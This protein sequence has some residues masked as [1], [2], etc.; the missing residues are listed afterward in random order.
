[1]R[2][3]ISLPDVDKIVGQFI[4]QL[5]VDQEHVDITV[6]DNPGFWLEK[7]ICFV[8][9][10]YYGDGFPVVKLNK[11][12]DYI[13]LNGFYYNHGV[14]TQEQFVERFNSCYEGKRFYRLLTKKEIDWLAKVMKERQI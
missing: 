4:V 14:Y 6:G 11:G 7:R 2:Q 9:R 5:G 3:I 10:L 8:S 13:I 12:E 1:M